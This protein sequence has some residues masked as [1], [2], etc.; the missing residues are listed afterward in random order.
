[1]RIGIPKEIKPDEF[2]VAAPPD[3]VRALV[4]QGHE[5]RVQSGAGEGCG[6]SDADYRLA[7]A[8]LCGVDEVWEKS[9]FIYK[10]KEPVEAE[11]PR[12]R[13]GQI[14]FTYFHLAT[15]RPLTDAV[16][17]SGCLAVA[18]ET[19]LDSSGALPCL[20]PMSEIAGRMSIQEGAKCLEKVSNGRGILLAGVPGVAPAQV[21]IVGGGV[22]GSNAAKMAA[23]LGARVTLLD[24]NLNR[25]RYLDEILPANVVEIFASEESVAQ[26][27]AQADLV[28]GAV[29]REGAPAPKVLTRAMVQ[30]MKPGAALV[31]VAI[32]QGGSSETSRPTTHS[33]P[34]YVEH[35]VVHYCVT[36]MPGGV[37]R[38]ATLA[39]S[40]ATL[41]YALRL[42]GQ[43]LK[44][45]FEADAGLAHGL[46]LAQGQVTHPAVA[47]W[48]EEKP[49][50]WAGLV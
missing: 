20:V 12:L 10:V 6:Y 37:A 9:G 45:A 32:D 3:A 5:L 26:A 30:N 43:G 34:T 19:I 41:P 42:A 23:G 8:A 22:V 50:P 40:N 28:V 29:L 25:L 49:R 39:L 38:T 13:Q 16:R 33:N 17:A 48:L 27:T 7:G 14:V 15:H 31:D 35:D 18:Y 1:M 44:A 2:R 11:W 4:R 47:Q 24:L 21:V 46:N 36:N